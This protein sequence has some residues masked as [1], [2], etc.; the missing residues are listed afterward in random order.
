MAI[1]IALAVLAS[2]SVILSMTAVQIVAQRRTLN[3]R[4]HQ[5]QAEWLAR[6]GVELAA[7]RLLEKPAA[8]TEEQRDLVPESKV[9]IAVEKT[10]E[11][12][13]RVTA[14]AAVNLQDGPAVARTANGRFRRTVSDGT[15]RLEALAP[16]KDVSP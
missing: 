5:L 11:D 6:A 3:Q 4:H 12:V 10:G 9:R 8:F 14:E 1:M 2:L 15:V 7:A 13:Y 16:E